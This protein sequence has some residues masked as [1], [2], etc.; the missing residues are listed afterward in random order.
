[1]VKDRLDEFQKM[2]STK[3]KDCCLSIS[4]QSKE[5]ESF[6]ELVTYAKAKLDEMETCLAQIADVHQRLLSVPGVDSSLNEERNT[7]YDC[8]N[9]LC[10]EVKGIT[11]RLNAE[12]NRAGKDR[13]VNLRIRENHTMAIIRRL[14]DLFA[15]F[16][17]EQ[18]KYRDKSQERIYSYMR[19]AGV[20]MTPDEVDEA[21]NKGEFFNTVSVQLATREKK[22]LFEDV[23]NRHEEIL[24]L[25]ASIRELHE[26]FQDIFMLVETQ[27]EMLDSVE[28]NVGMAADHVEKAMYGVTYA[29]KAKQ[30]GLKI[31]LCIGVC[32][33]VLLLLLLCWF[34]GTK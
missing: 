3:S 27:G 17:N 24:Q 22:A 14:Q 26:L 31:K 12:V 18:N 11:T 34:L 19:I 21:F 9:R 2:V 20:H 16:T 13:D 4:D 7:T 32:V 15:S 29:K 23:R 33:A 6:L 8:F 30:R 25:E 10:R 5:L 1:M 28:H